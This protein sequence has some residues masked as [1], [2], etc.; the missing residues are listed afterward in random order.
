M[1]IKKIILISFPIFVL[2]CFMSYWIEP[3]FSLW[4]MDKSIIL[5]KQVLPLISIFSLSETDGKFLVPKEASRFVLAG[6]NLTLFYGTY[7]YKLKIVPSCGGGDLGYMDAVRK[8]GNLGLGAKEIIAAKEGEEQIEEVQFYADSAFD[9]EFRLFSRGE[10]SFEIKE[11]FIE[12]EKIDF[13]T[14]AG[15]IW[16]KTKK[17]VQ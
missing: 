17:I 15:V 1:L 3:R 16:Q 5:K 8:K 9:Y 7:N 2:V 10:C 12:R 11:A 14:F 13:K 4:Q 6:S